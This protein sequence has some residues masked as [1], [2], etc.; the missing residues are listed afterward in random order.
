MERN[1]MK[2][3]ESHHSMKDN[4]TVQPC[5]LFLCG[6]YWLIDNL[7]VGSLGHDNPNAVVNGTL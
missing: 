3:M 4:F 7:Y 1:G 5:E 2:L 6:L